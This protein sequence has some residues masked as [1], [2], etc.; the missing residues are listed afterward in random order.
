MTDYNATHCSVAAEDVP[1]GA[2]IADEEQSVDETPPWSITEDDERRPP[3]VPRRSRG[4]DRAPAQEIL[5]Q[6]IAHDTARYGRQVA[7]ARTERAAD[8]AALEVG[9]KI[10]EALTAGIPKG[11][12]VKVPLRGKMPTLAL[13]RLSQIPKTEQ[14]VS[15]T[16]EVPEPIP[17]LN[18]RIALK[19]VEEGHLRS[20][21]SGAKE[22]TISAPQTVAIAGI[23]DELEKLRADNNSSLLPALRN[24]GI[25]QLIFEVRRFVR[26]NDEFPAN[27]VLSLGHWVDPSIAN[28]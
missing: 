20:D 8:I 12:S 13:T 18:I 4:G 25:E 23:I 15:S 1:G 9:E 28:S 2:E 26:N 19:P 21:I 24:A 6:I 7:H 17:T 10:R 22:R 3:S 14:V 5:S 11:E 16:A 27:I